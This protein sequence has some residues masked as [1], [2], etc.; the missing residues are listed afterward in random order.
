MNIKK[1]DNV[2]VRTGKEKGAKGKVLL[3]SADR[4][5]VVVEG[6]QKI[7]RHQKARNRNEKGVIIEKEASLAISNVA[8]IDPK[9]G[10]PTRLGARGT[11]KEKV[12]IAKKSG[13]A[14][15]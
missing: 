7:K 12:R 2:I 5:R 9:T 1:G 11:G 8:L 3:I 10:K 4:T 15:T 14:F 6:V 13:E